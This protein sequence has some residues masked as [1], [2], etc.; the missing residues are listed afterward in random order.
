MN[1]DNCIDIIMAA[2]EKV[3]TDKAALL[4]VLKKANAK[5]AGGK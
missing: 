5:L 2:L 4:E 3:N 1:K